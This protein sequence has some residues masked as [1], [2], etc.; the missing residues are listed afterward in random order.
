MAFQDPLY[1]RTSSLQRASSGLPPRG[2]TVAVDSRPQ[3][4]RR[5]WREGEGFGRS[6][7]MDGTW[8][9]PLLDLGTKGM[10]LRS[11]KCNKTFYLLW[12]D[13][14]FFLVVV[15]ESLLWN[16]FDTFKW[17]VWMVYVCWIL[18]SLWF[19]MI[20]LCLATS[21]PPPCHLPSSLG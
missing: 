3:R 21:C 1:R 17:C 4:G 2:A 12:C 11:R 15:S 19:E 6:A 14:S 9:H 10:S 20:D 5:K 8:T 18:T 7:A 13:F 16:Y